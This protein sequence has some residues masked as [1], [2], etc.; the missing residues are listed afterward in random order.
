MKPEPI[1]DIRAEHEKNGGGEDFWFDYI[2]DTGDSQTATYSIACL[3]LSDL[4]TSEDEQAGSDVKFSDPDGN[5]TKLPRGAF[6]LVGGDTA[7]HIADDPTLAHRFQSPFRWAYDDVKGSV[8][9]DPERRPIFGIPGNHDYYDSLDGFNRQFRKPITEEDKALVIRPGDKRKPQLS[10]PGFERRQEASFVAINLPNDWWLWALDAQSGKIDIRQREFFRGLNTEQ[11]PKKLILV[12][13]EPSVVFRRSDSEVQAETLDGLGLLRPFVDPDEKI[14]DGSCHLD[15]AGDV[16]HYARYWGPDSRPN[17]K[18]SAT[19]YASV[20]AGFGGAFLHPSQTVAGD[21]EEQVLY[22]PEE[23]SREAVA[24][25]LFNLNVIREGGYVWVAGAVAA[26]IVLLGAITPTTRTAT[27]WLLNLLGS[28]GTMESPPPGEPTA[29]LH[30]FLMLL[31]FAA[32]G[33]LTYSAIK[34]FEKLALKARNDPI[35]S[36]DYLFVRY[37]LYA[38]AIAVGFAIWR[39]GSQPAS[40]VTSD[41]VFLAVVLSLLGGF[42]YFAVSGSSRLNGPKR[43]IV[44]GLGVFHGVLQL[45]VP[46]LAVLVG[47]PVAYA[48]VVLT[49]LFFWPV[50]AW[51]ACYNLPWVLLVIW[52]LHGGL[53]LFLPFGLA[54]VSQPFSHEFPEAM[55]SFAAAAVL[56]AVMSCVWLGWYL[57][58]ALAFDAHNNE[59]GGAARIDKYRGMIRFRIRKNPKTGNDEITAFV[60]AFDEPKKE[61]SELDLG[62][63]LRLVDVFTLSPEKPVDAPVADQATG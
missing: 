58:V 8:D 20:L 42:V 36:G 57:A 3:C 5:L 50:G 35:T 25:R 44:I 40:V 13:P 29:L 51:V 43:G 12:T 52:L 33:Y 24:K 23:K 9:F 48:A 41:L 7:Y 49:A 53:Q 56:G 18:P 2:S 19:N 39:F 10:I 27:N 38:A 6:L 34:K 26:A 17:G 46:L 60:I 28:Y 63:N 62:H 16:H 45:A 15:I 21:I 1:T 22:P 54:S 30:S 55:V 61:G 31:L 59:A 11:P 4:Y 37:R 47:G 32:A 14:P